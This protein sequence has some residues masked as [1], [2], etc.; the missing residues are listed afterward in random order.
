M[1]AT[2][3]KLVNKHLRRVSHTFVFQFKKPYLY[4]KS[5]KKVRSESVHLIRVGVLSR[6]KV[7]IGS[8]QSR[9]SSRD[10]LPRPPAAALTR[11]QATTT[12][13]AKRSPASEP[14]S[15]YSGTPRLRS[16]LSRRSCRI[17]TGKIR[18]LP[19]EVSR[20][21][22]VKVSES[23]KW[24]RLMVDVQLEL[25]FSIKNKQEFDHDYLRSN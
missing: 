1:N 20:N 13:F 19:L 9:L 5:R 17:E 4:A 11:A 18:M 25:K 10:R 6:V 24:I 21:Y 3:V 14:Q 12:V 16:T 22:V 7:V 8:W 23:Q 2:I 15:L